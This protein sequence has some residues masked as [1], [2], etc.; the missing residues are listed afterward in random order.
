M[1]FRTVSCYEPFSSHCRPLNSGLH[2]CGRA[3]VQHTAIHIQ[4]GDLDRDALPHALR[5]GAIGLKTAQHPVQVLQLATGYAQ[6]QRGLDAQHAQSV[7][8]VCS[9]SLQVSI[10]IIV[11]FLS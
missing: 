8:D 3:A 7:L 6:L 9:A 2:S 1:S 4:N 5:Y 11:K 10:L